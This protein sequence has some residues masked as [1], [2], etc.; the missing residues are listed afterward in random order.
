MSFEVFAFGT[1]ELWQEMPADTLR[2]R[3]VGDRTLA[4]HTLALGHLRG[5]VVRGFSVHDREGGGKG[6]G[7]L[8]T[9]RDERRG[10]NNDNRRWETGEIEGLDRS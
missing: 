2:W 9:G 3:T 7:D 4:T 10:R 8:A 1:V 5:S 6:D